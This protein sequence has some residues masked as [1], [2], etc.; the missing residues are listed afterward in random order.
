M[1]ETERA[2]QAVER[3]RKT[4][5]MGST[6]PLAQDESLVFKRCQIPSFRIKPETKI[7]LGAALGANF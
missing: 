4:S 7:G 2:D 5:I 3:R 1:H 6:F